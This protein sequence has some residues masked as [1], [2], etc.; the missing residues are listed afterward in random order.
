MY[1]QRPSVSS[2]AHQTASASS[3]GHKV[4]FVLLLLSFEPPSIAVAVD[5]VAA[6]K[7]AGK[8]AAETGGT[9]VAAAEAVAGHLLLHHLPYPS[10]KKK[11]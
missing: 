6:D 9:P 11:M 10:V 5:N 7:S 1:S 8:G 2:S 3:S 4:S